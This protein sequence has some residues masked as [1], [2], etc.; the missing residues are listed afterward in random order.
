VLQSA[1]IRVVEDSMETQK[2]S[3]YVERVARAAAYHGG[4]GRLM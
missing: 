2:P 4:G 3:R 1:H